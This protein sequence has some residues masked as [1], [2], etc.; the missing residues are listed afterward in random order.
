MKKL[1]KIG[2]LFG[3]LEVYEQAASRLY[4]ASNKLMR[5]W[6]CRCH[7]CGGFATVAEDTLLAG[8]MRSCGCLLYRRKKGSA[9]NADTPRTIP[10][11]LQPQH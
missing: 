7:L 2:K 4:N 10:R 11:R 1:I 5:F 8:S 6:R 9:S 3:Q